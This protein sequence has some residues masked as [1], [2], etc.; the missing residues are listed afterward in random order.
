MGYR[1]IKA[2]REKA[3]STLDM[4]NRARYRCKRMAIFQTAPYRNATAIANHIATIILKTDE[5]SMALAAL[6]RQWYELECVKREWRG[7][8]RLSTTSMKE[9]LEA[10]RASMK[11]ATTTLDV[12][13]E[14]EEPTVT[15]PPTP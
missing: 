7:L 11:E 8:P 1:I 9:L 6:V 5:G 3:R 12:C 2:G 15:A 13:T 4:H 14:V 10:K